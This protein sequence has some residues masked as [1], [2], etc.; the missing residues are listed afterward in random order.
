MKTVQVLTPVNIGDN[1][2]PLYNVLISTM[3]DEDKM[4]FVA[5]DMLF[6]D[7]VGLGADDQQRLAAYIAYT[8]R[9]T[10]F[11]VE[12][13]FGILLPEDEQLLNDAYKPINPLELNNLPEEVPIDVVDTPDDDNKVD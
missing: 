9:V 6:S 3:P 7:F 2:K 11:N 1:E 13:A 12:K 8:L 10:A 4:Q 5:H